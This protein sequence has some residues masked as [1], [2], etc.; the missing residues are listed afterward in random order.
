MTIAES[1]AFVRDFQ[2]LAGDLLD[3][4]DVIICPPFTALWP[5]AQAL[6][7][8]GLQL[9]AQDVAAS[10]DPARTG[11]ISAALLAD[12]GCR[13][14]MLGHWEVRRYGGDDDA[15]VKRKLHLALAAGLAPILLIGQGRDEEGAREII[16]DRRL[17]QLLAGCQAEQVA[18]LVFVY[19]P[20]A[21]IGLDAPTQAEQVAGGCGFIRHW[22][23]RRWGNPAAEAVRIIYGGSVGPEYAAGLLSSADVDGLGASRRGRN[24]AT[25]I[26]IVRQVAR[27]KR[28][29]SDQ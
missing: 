25:F 3:Q 28:R 6:A 14:V 5:V 29:A 16:L 24:P 15:T 20:E 9:G 27:V 21:A 7:G 13:W 2:G 1:L 26:E 22:L 10:T 11:Q 12:A 18:K 17:S 4:V 8:S 19:E 23:R